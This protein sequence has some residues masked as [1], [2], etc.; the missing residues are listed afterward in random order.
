LREDVIKDEDEA[1]LTP[2]IHGH[3]IELFLRRNL[4]AKE[5][6]ASII[7]TNSRGDIQPVH[8]ELVHIHNSI[9]VVR[10][11]VVEARGVVQCLWFSRPASL[12]VHVK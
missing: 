3:Q 9:P 1:E 4:F 12:S 7:R 8:V 2:V 6:D 5:G 10:H 11:E